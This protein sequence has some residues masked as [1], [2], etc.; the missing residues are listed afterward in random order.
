[1]FNGWDVLMLIILLAVVLPLAYFGCKIGYEKLSTFW[2]IKLSARKL[3]IWDRG[4]VAKDTLGN[5]PRHDICHNWLRVG[6]Y[7]RSTLA[8]RYCWL[9]RCT[10]FTAEDAT[11]RIAAPEATVTRSENNVIEFAERRN[12]SFRRVSKAKNK[13]FGTDPSVA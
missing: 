4:Y 11:P 7:P 9:C 1:M 5:R 12:T 2:R 13:P 10:V 8:M 6:I 3:G